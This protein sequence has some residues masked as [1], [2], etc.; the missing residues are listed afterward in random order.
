[1]S[2]DF[3]G[4]QFDEMDWEKVTVEKAG[5][6]M[7]HKE[8]VQDEE[9]GMIVNLVKYPAGFINPKH[10]HPCAHGMYVLKGILHTSRG[11]FKPGAFLWFPEGEVMWHGATDEEDVEIVF[12][13]NK[14]FVINYL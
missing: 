10:D 12:I 7:F 9:T 5:K 8:L 14:K 13:T 4:I 1:M 11:D 2:K 3:I 6:I